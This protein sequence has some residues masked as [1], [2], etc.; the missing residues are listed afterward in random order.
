M[1]TYVL[2]KLLESAPG[3]YD[4]G[5]AIL[6]LGRMSA[7]YDRLAAEIQSGQRVL[8]VGCGSGALALRAAHR[9]ARVKAIDINPAMLEMAQH[10]VKAAGLSEKIELAEMGVAELPGEKPASFDV[11]ASILCFSELSEDEIDFTL[12]EIKRILKPGGVFLLADEVQPR[13]VFCKF[14]NGL[15]RIPLVILTYLISQTTTR[16]L[17]N[18]PVKVEQAGFRITSLKRSKLQDFAEIRAAKLN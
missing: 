8:D 11:I 15:I 4:R 5:I 12:K 6:T 7:V 18:L 3:R 10:K 13:N 14:L 9:G 1:S 2:M 16:A 17:K